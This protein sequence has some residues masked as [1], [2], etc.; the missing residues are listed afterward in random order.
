MTIGRDTRLAGAAAERAT[1][2]PA[3]LAAA[4]LVKRHRVRPNLAATV[5]LLAG[6]GERLHHG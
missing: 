5:A 3:D 6:L 4:W 1:I 2:P